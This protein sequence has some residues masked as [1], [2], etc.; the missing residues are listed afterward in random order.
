MDIQTAGRV[1]DRLF[2]RFAMRWPRDFLMEYEGLKIDDVKAEWA[3]DLC[4][5]TMDQ[6][7]AA[8]DAVKVNPFPPTLGTFLAYCKAERSRAMQAK[9]P[10]RFT[11]EEIE[12]N[13]GRI[14]DMFEVLAKAKRMPA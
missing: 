1:V 7:A 13:K 9:L 12:E 14:K 3:P 10:R 6:V 8:F 2:M 5:F 4:D 11:P